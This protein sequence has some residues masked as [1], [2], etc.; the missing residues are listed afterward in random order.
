MQGPPLPTLLLQFPH[1]QPVSPIPTLQGGQ[2]LL[3][4]ALP[5]LWTGMCLQ[6]EGRGNHKPHFN[7][8]SFHRD[9]SM[10]QNPKI[11]DSYLLSS[12]LGMAPKGK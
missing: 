4:N 7:Y 9:F 6:A 3:V 8:F 1:L 12:F 11:V 10:V 2:V 5:V